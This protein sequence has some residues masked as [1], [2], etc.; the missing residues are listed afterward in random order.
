MPSITEKSKLQSAWASDSALSGAPEVPGMC[1][2]KGLV[3]CYIPEAKS[4]A[5][6]ISTQ[7]TFANLLN[8][9]LITVIRTLFPSFSSACLLCF[10]LSVRLPGKVRQPQAA[11]P[12]LGSQCL[13]SQTG[14]SF[15]P[16]HCICIIAPERNVIVS[17][18]AMCSS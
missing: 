14:T 3:H 9:R 6:P 1:T 5:K 11:Q 4:S 8:N 18:W 7:C 2:S 12:Q 13:E 15:L 10:L 16:S 17:F